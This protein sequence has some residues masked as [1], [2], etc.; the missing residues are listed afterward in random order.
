[1]PNSLSSI[2]HYAFYENQLTSVT[3]P[4]GLTSIGEWAFNGNQLTSV[5]LPD[6]LTTIGYA[7]F[8]EN[9]LTSVT[10]PA[11]LTSIG[12]LAFAYNQLTSVHLPTSLQEIY[13]DAFKWNPVE[14]VR[15]FD[16]FRLYIDR[17]SIIYFP[18][19]SAIID[20]CFDGSP[21]VNQYTML[22]DS[23]GGS[24]IDSVSA[25]Y[26]TLINEPA[27]PTRTGYT[28]AFWSKDVTGKIAW[29]F[30]TDTVQSDTTLYAQW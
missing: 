1:M 12:A 14:E 26:D 11:G 19:T 28:F 27:A 9:Q 24:H 20:Y 3:F 15:M 4:A 5:T 18:S 21:A 6:A 13:F 8:S 22:F 17:Y 30:L 29:D 2:G 16:I 23:Q 7:A 10:F 25:D